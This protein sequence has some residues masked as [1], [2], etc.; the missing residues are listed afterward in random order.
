MP[1]VVDSERYSSSS[2]RGTWSR[3]SSPSQH[4]KPVT[5]CITIGLIN[6]MPQAAFATTER[7]FISVLDAA[8]TGFNVRLHLY[9][10]VHSPAAAAGDN[11]P[12]NCF[13]SIDNLWE[14]NLDGLIVTGKEP[15]TASL[16][17]EPC[18][19]KLTQVV[20][21][22]RAKTHSTVWSCLAAHAAVL[23]LDGIGRRKNGEKHFGVFEC[24]RVSTHPLLAGAPPSF[25]IPHSRW[26]GLC[27]E[28]LVSRGYSVLTRIP[29]LGVDT[30]VKE[31]NSLFVFFQGHPEYDSDT[32]LREYRRDVGRY[33]NSETTT[34]PSI[35]AGYFDR[36]TQS[37]LTAL[38]DKALSSRNQQTLSS[39]LTALEKTKVK[40]SWRP[41]TTCIYRNWLEHIY[42]RKNGS[43]LG[44]ANV[45]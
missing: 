1:I 5:E 44:D 8:S 17:D 16:S 41:V 30:F 36:N 18:W 38:R 23:Y 19:K 31:E 9:S 25:R 4:Q 21:W 3:R 45:A 7:Q 12:G 40:H 32:L 11:S 13:S 20:E 34:Y 35:P 42:A 39:V 29:G 22:A 24:D 28:E 37:T 15:I 43:C 6:N 26:N 27:E 2:G 14:T 10:L 33:I